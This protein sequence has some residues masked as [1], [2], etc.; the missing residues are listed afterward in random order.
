MGAKFQYPPSSLL[1]FELVQSIFGRGALAN[2]VLNCLSVCF[3]V[4][5]AVATYLIAR[6]GL[7]PPRRALLD[8]A[9]P[10]MFVVLCYPLLK[11]LEI[12]QIQS[13]LNGLFALALLSFTRG[14]T[15]AAGLLV[16][17][18]ATIKPQMGLFLLW[19]LLHRE[20]RFAKAMGACVVVVGLISL[21]LYGLRPHLE[22]LE[23][24]SMISRHGESYYAN[25][26][27]NGLLLRA[28]DLGPNL[29]FT[30]MQFAPYNPWVRYAT[31]LS[32]LLFISLALLTRWRARG[33][34][35]PARLRGI[36]FGL[37]ALCFTVASPIAWEHH[38]GI[39]PALFAAALAPMLQ[40]AA[41]SRILW[42]AIGAAWILL[43]TRISAVGA[44]ADTSLNFLQS[45]FFFGALI[46]LGILYQLCRPP[47]E[48]ASEAAQR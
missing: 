18:M 9:L 1:G 6:P 41:I 13:Y 12:G 17:V 40:Q 48:V 45:H 30:V 21:A 25:Q 39:V 3:F 43:C 36:H 20:Y 2:P 14:R 27:L 5:F 23:V 46:L 29:S 47:R 37:V 31:L 24:L 10:F 44:L 42:L 4:L 33:V 22:Y 35:A 32:S 28:L 8:H 11:A 16:G 7:V 19:A 38:Y 15:I 26:S 34:P